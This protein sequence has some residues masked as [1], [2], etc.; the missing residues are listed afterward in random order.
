MACVVVLVFT[1]KV[2]AMQENPSQGPVGFTS[3]IH[4][5]AKLETKKL[6]MGAA[7]LIDAFVTL[8]GKSAQIGNAVN[9]QDNARLLNFGTS[10]KGRGDL[11]LGDGTFTAHGVTFVGRVRIGEAC[12]TGINAVVQNATLGNGSFVGLMAQ[13]LGPS[14]EHPIEIPE[15]SLLLF[16]ARITEQELKSGKILVCMSS[17]LHHVMWD[18]I[19]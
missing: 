9:L 3:F 5:S 12:G 16:G 11:V 8:E 4:P 15:A 17:H 19:A 1:Q 2:H 6:T 14:P 13:I 7:S 18:M 10:G